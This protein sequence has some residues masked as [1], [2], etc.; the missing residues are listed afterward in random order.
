MNTQVLS[1]EFGLGVFAIWNDILNE[2]P[3]LS[4]PTFTHTSSCGMMPSCHVSR[5]TLESTCNVVII[6]S[7]YMYVS[8]TFGFGPGTEG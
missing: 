8:C 6:T 7:M 4:P 3:P 1:I 2:E 5:W